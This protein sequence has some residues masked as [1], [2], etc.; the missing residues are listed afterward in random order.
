MVPITIAMLAV[1]IVAFHIS[2]YAGLIAV[3]MSFFLSLVA[4]RARERRHDPDRRH[5][6]SHAAHFRRPAPG[7]DL[8]ELAAAGIAANS[9]S[10]SADLLDRPQKRLPAGRQSRK[11]FLAQFYGVFFGTLAIVPI[12]FL[13][14]PDKEQLE[15]LPR[16]H[17]QWEP[18]PRS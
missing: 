7:Q 3:G 1:Q 8:P 12:W 4:C 14:V 9:A 18:S 15:S 13:M 10:S 11:Q 17:A 5:G 6:Q 16:P 2:W